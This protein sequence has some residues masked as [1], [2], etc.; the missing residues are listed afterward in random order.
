MSDERQN[1][2]RFTGHRFLAQRLVL[3]TLTGRQIRISQIRSSSPTSPGLLPHEVSLLRLL[4]AV[5]NGTVI[6]FSY[7]GTTVVYKPGLITGSVSGYGAGAGGIINHDIPSTCTRGSSYFLLPLCLLAPFGKAPLKV[8]FT[9]AGVIT[10][11]T[12]HGDISADSVRTAILPVYEQFGISGD[13]ELRILRRSN[14]GRGGKGGGGEIQLVFGRQVRLPKTIHLLN[15][16]RVKRIRGVAYATGLGG[17]NNAR[18]IESARGLLNP[19]VPDTYIYSDVSAAPLLPV[20]GK[21]VGKD[22]KPAK[23]KV[24]VGFGLSLV[25]Y[26]ST[27]VLYSA[28]MASPAQGGEPPEDV[29]RKCALQLLETVEQGGCVSKTAA[30]T[31]LILMAMGSEDVGRVQVGRAVIGNEEMIGLARDLRTFGASGWGLRDASGDND[32]IIISIVGRGIGN[33]GRKIA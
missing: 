16:G 2:V 26:T 9:G 32:D 15:P 3:S 33:V 4:E 13:I 24:G 29:G 21:A 8:H 18:M 31:M 11:A 27:D 20:D 1:I 28:D 7:T 22:G 25:A 23:Q 10:S 30:S 19:L 14:P 6:E 17:A 5:T 12:S